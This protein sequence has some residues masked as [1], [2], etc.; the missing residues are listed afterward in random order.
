MVRE[1]NRN[2]QILS[3]INVLKKEVSY[4]N[5]NYKKHFTLI[6]YL[7]PNKDK[8]KLEIESVDEEK[9]NT[10]GLVY[11][12]VIGGKIFK[13][14]HSITSIKK[15]VQSYNCGKTEYRISGDKFNN[16][17]FYLTKSIGN[18]RES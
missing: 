17:L 10:R 9:V 16:Q 7:I 14:G 5:F 4:E 11:V 6:C 1:K 15:R 13:I 18:W 2:I 8:E 3:S 12:F